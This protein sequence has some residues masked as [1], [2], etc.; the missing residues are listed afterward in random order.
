MTIHL[1][2][3]QQAFVSLA[4]SGRSGCING[5]AGTGKTTAVRAAVE[6]LLATGNI[7]LLQVSTGNKTAP[8]LRAGLPGIVGCAFTR[9]ASGNLRANFPP[10]LQVH[11]MTLHALIEYAPVY[12]DAI[13]D[14]G[15]LVSKMVFE[16]QRNASNPLPQE[17]HTIIIDESSTINMD[18]FSNLMDALSHPVQFL[19][20]GDIN[21]ISTVFGETMFGHALINL[22]SIELTHVY[23]Q[24]L[25]SPFIRLAHRILSGKPIPYDELMSLSIED[26]LKFACW[27]PKTTTETAES[28]AISLL[29]KYYTEG[30]YNPYQDMVI[31]PFNV[32][33]GTL[34]VSKAI[35]NFID[36]ATN[37]KPTEVFCS[38]RKIYY[39]EGDLV[40]FNNETY[41]ITRIVPNGLFRTKEKPRKPGTYD[42]YGIDRSLIDDLA[43]DF[44]L[45][46]A[47][48]ATFDESASESSHIITIK[49]TY[50]E[51][52]ELNLSTLGEVSNLALGYA[53]TCH[54]AQGL[55]A[56]RVFILTHKSHATL[57][58]RE[59]L[60]T[61][62]TRVK[63][64]LVV[65]GER[66][67]FI[68]AINRQSIVG[69]T[70]NETLT[71]LAT[72]LKDTRFE[73][74]RLTIK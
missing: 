72:K 46:F 13:D 38:F 41:I 39:A 24:A 50:D 49:S 40:V 19:F 64:H 51:T 14:E 71:Y 58:N 23:R 8:R 4:I 74:N 18:L 70:L 22:P 31:I 66:D 5:A 25:D 63:K 3:E 45:S 47:P 37:T 36:E 69:T 26:E 59:W 11:V 48:E 30:N 43:F 53:T 32:K 33:F 54:K 73:K 56:E 10:D 1:N 61:A 62:V 65:V 57:L 21:Q 42:R 17:I 60:Y 20:I 35:A 68:K 12:Y 15:N 29:K 44:D 55:E 34:E 16:P 9:R 7:P 2:A 52:I 67:L 6:A 27:K 28:T